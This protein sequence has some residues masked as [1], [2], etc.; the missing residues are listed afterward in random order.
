MTLPEGVALNPSAADGLSS[1]RGERSRPG[2]RRRTDV[3]G[4]LEG[5]RRS[6]STRRCCRTRSPARRIWRRRITNPFGALIALYIVA[7]DPVSG[8]L[9]KLAGQ[10][11]PNPVTGQLVATFKE[12][13]RSAVRRLQPELLRRLPGAV[14]HTAVVR[15]VYDDGVVRAVVGQ[16]AGGILSKFEI[17]AG[18][19]DTPCA[20]PR[21]FQPGFE[22]GTTSIQAGGYTPLTM[23]MGRPDAEQ[24]LQAIQL[25]MPAGDLGSAL[26]REALRGT[27][28]RRRA[29]AARKAR[30]GN[31]R[32]R[33]PGRQPLHRGTAGRSTSP[34][35]TRAPRSGCRS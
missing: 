13:P 20:N 5:R 2:R 23:T 4:I 7:R 10:V 25:H 34:A 16:R 22:A 28:G 11:T 35:P 14:G 30:S 1:C 3:P 24:N 21:P 26:E 27:A 9:V 32:E 31:D 19:D 6:K 15:L 17:T 12:T 29:R 18:P 8:V 33:R